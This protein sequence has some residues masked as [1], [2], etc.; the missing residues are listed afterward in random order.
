MQTRKL[1]RIATF[2]ALSGVGA[3]IKVPSPTGTVALDSLPG[4]LAAALL[5][6]WP[7]A[8][9]GALGHLFSAWVVA[10]PLGL[11]LHL[12]IAAQM[13]VSVSVFGYLFRNGQKAAAIAVGIILNGIVAPAML[14]PMLGAGFFFAMVAP[15]VIIS[16]VNIMLAFML[17]QSS[18][19]QKVGKEVEV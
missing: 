19:I 2:I 1:V 9:V 13:A 12:I 3:Y 6:G 14:I 18:A 8:V 7:G 11:P 5:G 15:L 4:Y 16:A 10:M 17:A